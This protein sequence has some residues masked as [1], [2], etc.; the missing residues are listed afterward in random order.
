MTGLA[1]WL[2]ATYPKDNQ[3]RTLGVSQLHG[4]AGR[5]LPV[6]GSTCCSA[7][8]AFVLLI[9]C[10]NIAN[11][12][13][14]R[15]AARAR[16]ISIRAAIGA[17]RRHLF[18]PRAGE[19]LVLAIGGR[20]ARICWWGTGEW[21]SSRRSDLEDV[22]R[23]AQARVDGPVLAF[24]VGLTVLSGLVFGLVP[25]LRT[26]ARPPHEALKEGGRT[27]SRAG[28]RDRLR[29][30]LVVAEIALALV[31][32][33]GAGLLIRSSVALNAVDPG[34][35]PRGVVAGRISL[36]ETSYQTPERSDAGVRA[37]RGAGGGRPRGGCRPRW[38][39]PRRSRAGTAMGSCPRAGRSR[40]APRSTR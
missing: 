40:S 33:T 36:P 19:S 32:L 13:L 21:R 10:A 23:L 14:A 5:R 38:S 39:P 28:S 6:R 17:G 8:S 16:E 30:V 20:A 2:E 26:A 15:G 29:N 27:G 11:L 25:A 35:D 12:L 9:A 37:D 18:A 7:R 3:D 34:F 22:P 31:L 1:R 4:G 24:A